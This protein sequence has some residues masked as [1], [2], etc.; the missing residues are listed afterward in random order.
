MKTSIKII[1]RFFFF[2]SFFLFIFLGSCQTENKTET[3]QKVKH[4]EWSKN[5][6]IYEVNIRQYTPEGTFNAFAGHLPRL[7]EMGIDILWLMPVHPI[8]IENR[9]GTLGSYYSVKDYF[10]VNA[11]FGTKDD[12]KNLVNKA[13]E[14]GMYVIIDWVANHS[15][16]DT[17]QIKNN[18]DWYSK[19]EKGEIISPVDDWSDVADFNYDNPEMRDFMLDALKYWVTEFN[20]DGYRCDVAAMVPIDFWNKA[21]YELDKIKPVFMLAEANEPEL[22][23]YAFDMTY[24]WDTHFL[25]NEI[26]QSK[27]RVSDLVNL[28]ESEKIK[29]PADAYH[30]NFTSNHDEN[31][32]K[33]TEYERMGN[34]V[35]TFTVLSVTLPGMPLVY[36]GQESC[37]D[38][39]LRFFDK[40]TVDWN[41]NCDLDELYT[42]LLK[43]KKENK[44]LWNGEFGGMLTRI[45]TT[46]D[47][48]IFAFIREKDENRIITIVNLSPEK[49]DFSI[50][51]NL[52]TDSFSEIFTNQALSLVN[53]LEPWGYLVYKTY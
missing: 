20:I 22:H 33:G 40:D 2:S 44:A 30:M 17:E 24:A 3:F 18:P 38:K 45:A 8:G 49:V 6:S 37:M 1:S 39:R 50:T 16:W 34:A 10:D 29:Y 19:N 43:L 12:F 11:E 31:T 27:K 23:D 28:L 51:E 36:S 47:D 7:K 13:H 46:A 4:P 15:S 52:S 5:A 41:I 53:K 25:M 9:K 42:A 32:W 48:K 21:R 26:A 35:R 14:L